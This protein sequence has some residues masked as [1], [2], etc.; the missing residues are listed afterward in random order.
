MPLE[1]KNKHK[2]AIPNL[3]QHRVTFWDQPIDVLNS[4]QGKLNELL[5]ANMWVE[6]VNLSLQCS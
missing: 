4:I 1:K 5:D 2:L 3:I 6:T